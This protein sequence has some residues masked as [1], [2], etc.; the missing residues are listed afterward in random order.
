MMMVEF[1]LGRGIFMCL[2]CACYEV[3]KRKRKK[4]K[5]VK[6]K[7]S[8]RKKK[9]E[10]KKI[11]KIKTKRVRII[12]LIS[13]VCWFEVWNEEEVLLKLF[14]LRLGELITSLGL[15]KFLFRLALGLI[16]CFLTKPHYNLESPWD[17]RF[18]VCDVNFRRNA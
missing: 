16:T 1:K 3:V 8:K 9:I 6:K 7:E 10:K 5:K 4:R 14:C 17:S 12:V 13:D 2:C 15:E 11:W 18:C